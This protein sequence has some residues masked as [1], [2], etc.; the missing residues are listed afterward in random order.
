MYEQYGYTSG[1]LTGAKRMNIRYPDVLGQARI[2]SLLW[3]GLYDN[4]GRLT[5][6]SYPEPQK[7]DPPAEELKQ[8]AAIM[9]LVTKLAMLPEYDVFGRLSTIRAQQGTSN[10]VTLASG[11]QYNQ[12]GQLLDVSWL[13]MREQRTYSAERQQLTGLKVQG[14]GPGLDLLYSYIKA[15]APANE[16]WNNGQLRLQQDM[17]SGETVRYEYDTLR[18]L[19]LAETTA[20]STPWGQRYTYDGFG[21]L[22]GQESTKQ[23]GLPAV[24]LPV[25]GSNNRSLSFAY[26]GNG[27]VTADGVHTY[28]YDAANRLRQVDSG[29]RYSYDPENRRVYEGGPGE[30]ASGEYTFW[31]PDGRRLG[32]YRLSTP[33]QAAVYVETMTVQ[34]YLG[35]RVIASGTQPP[36]AAYVFV[37]V[38]TDRGGSVRVS[39]SEQRRYLPYGKELTA[40]ADGALKFATYFRDTTGLDYA[41]Q[42]YYQPAWG[43]FL[44]PDPSMPGDVGN[45]GSWNMYG[46]VEG[47]PINSNDPLGL[48]QCSVSSQRTIN[49]PQNPFTAVEL[50]CTSV[51]GSVQLRDVVSFDREI[52]GSDINTAL[53]TFG[54]TVDAM[55][56]ADFAARLLASVSRVRAALALP[57]C[58]RNFRDADAASRRAGSIGFS[59]QGSLRYTTVDGVIKPA[60][61]SPGLG[62]YNPFTGSISLNSRVNWATPAATFA[63]LDGAV[64]MNDLLRGQAAM[65]G[66]TAV[67]ASQ[68]MDL[69]ILHELSHYSGAIGNPDRNPT[70]ERML[71]LDCIR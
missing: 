35:S 24:N 43:R 20:G 65:L 38:V 59:D 13:G 66:V 61:R 37:P 50:W 46:Y 47:D 51:A 56:H 19:T 12:A 41:N 2:V 16:T 45:P 70:V 26:D 11:F 52:T 60:R 21:N 31:S 71:W 1:G 44:T 63:L 42:R 39:G 7:L 49:D 69:T 55:E 14:S 29:R 9:N 48:A 6:E 28:T 30:T 3:T 25:D 4:E 64:W 36:S 57:D 34:L 68:L 67:S 8:S 23:P 53:A 40:T 62:R 27:N 58:A 22:T 10:P 18:R 17:A 5:W 32:K 54:R 15:G 33:G